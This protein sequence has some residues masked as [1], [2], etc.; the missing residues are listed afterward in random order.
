MRRRYVYR[1][2]P[3]TGELESVEVSADWEDAPRQ[4]LRVD[5]SY[6]DGARATDGTDISSLKKRREY[7]KANNLADTSDFSQHWEKAAKARADYLE[8]KTRNPRLR[9]AIGRTAY[10]LEMRNRRK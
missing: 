2:N 4:P 7:F 6:L 5:V 8:G 3:D 10:Q 1:R 9:E